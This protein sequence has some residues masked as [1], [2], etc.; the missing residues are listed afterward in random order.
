MS[1]WHGDSKTRVGFSKDYLFATINNSLSTNYKLMK[2]PLGDSVKS[3]NKLGWGL[4]AP[5]TLSRW[6]E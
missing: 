3:M 2:S 6:E 1:V 5:P 4:I